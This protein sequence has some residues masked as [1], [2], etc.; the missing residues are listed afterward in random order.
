MAADPAAVAVAVCGVQAQ[1][2][3]SGMLSLRVRGTDMTLHTTSAAFA[4][5][6]LVRTWLMRG[7][8]HLVAADDAR[9]LLTVLG[10][11]NARRDT[12]RRARLGLDD[13]SCDRMISAIR[14]ALS[15]G[16]LTRLQLREHLEGKGMTVRQGQAMSHL[17]GL[18]ASRGVLTLT[19]QRGRFNTFSL[20]DDVVPSERRRLSVERA[21]AELAR[22]YLVAY[23]PATVR[24]FAVWSGVPM[25]LARRAMSAIASDVIG[26]EGPLPGLLRLK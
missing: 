21:E 15:D 3:A 9:W 12:T 1:D 26:M 24:D 13:A 5:G 10:P 23:A 8:L 6:S 17:R 20:L 7:T 14:T 18:A 11:L 19:E 25:A 16:P 22:R 4:R 2:L